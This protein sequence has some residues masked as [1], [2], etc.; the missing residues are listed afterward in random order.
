MSQLRGCSFSSEKEE[1]VRG[2]SGRY[3]VSAEQLGH[4]VG[5]LSFSSEKM[6][7]IRNFRNK[8]K[9]PMNMEPIIKHLS[10]SS[11]KEEAR[12]ILVTS[13]P[14]YGS[15]GYISSPPSYGSSTGG[16]GAPPSYGG[17]SFPDMGGFSGGF[18]GGFPG[19]PGIGVVP[20]DFPSVFSSGG[21]SVT[22]S[23]SSSPTRDGP[24][25]TIHGCH[26]TYLT[27]R[28]DGSLDLA[29]EAYDWERWTMVHLPGGKV[30]F[31]N[32]HGKYLQSLPDRR[33]ACGASTPGDWEG[34]TLIP[35]GGGY[36]IRSYHGTYLRSTP[37][38]KPDFAATV[39]R[40]WEAFR[41]S[42]AS[43]GSFP[44]S[45]SSSF[46]SSF[47]VPGP[48]SGSFPFPTSSSSSAS[49]REGIVTL[50]SHHGTYLT[51]RPD[52]TCDLAREAH[53][54]ERWN[55]VH[56]P[57][58]KVAF[59]NHHGK[60]LQAF[61]DRRAGCEAREAHDWESF[62][63]IPHRSGYA[64]RSSHGTY[65]R[66][67]IDGK[68]DFDSTEP[69]EW[70]TFRLVSSGGFPSS[71][72]SPSSSGPGA[73]LV[74]LHSH[75]RTFLTGR[76]DGTCDL[77][78]EAYDWERWTLVHLSGGKVAF[79]DHHGKYLQAFPDRRAGCE[80]R[81]AN[82]WESF[83]LVP[84]RGGYAVRSHHGTYLRATPESRPDFDSTS[85][86]EWETFHI[87]RA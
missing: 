50:Q 53:D 70:E 81:E 68:P 69:R 25:T 30:A 34:Y 80:A 18:P 67:T 16:Y 79:R 10:F 40:E 36:A 57:G 33:A 78:R 20:G 48:S 41:L 51:G 7:A 82:D 62:T 12:N 9:D 21:F 73:G 39:P 13:T 23:S 77:A 37:E 4:I 72:G 43:S 71:G 83:T 17:A 63:L 1:L 11:E 86:R 2:F 27:G 54:W 87:N 29:R 85:P 26:N 74:T 14:A 49:V 61:P 22:G 15:S 19:F 60:F 66:G 59:K 28:P 58:G 44:S 46:P 8:I 42:G 35:H 5:T 52:G 55:L 45:G 24:V 76:P 3:I 38:G 84:H 65:L 64:I 75:H 6:D 32:H 47:P 31:R 56:V